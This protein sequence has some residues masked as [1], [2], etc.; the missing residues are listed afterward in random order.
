MMSSGILN[1]PRWISGASAALALVL[2]P[3]VFAASDAVSERPL[4]TYTQYHGM[5]AHGDNQ[6]LLR[7]YADG[8]VRVHRQPHM[9]GAGDYLMQLEAGAL[10]RLV[11]MLEREGLTR[12]DAAA[13]S[14]QRAALAEQHSRGADGRMR[15]GYA[16]SDPTDTRIVLQLPAQDGSQRPHSIVWRDVGMDAR[17]FPALAPIQS[18]ARIAG[19]LEALVWHPA[20]RAQAGGSQ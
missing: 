5:L 4:I 10:D 1:I 9:R 12:W 6:P 14:A 16:N 3:T 11:A 8:Q 13:V 2:C 7:I 15:V 17:M 19:E 20:L 18:L